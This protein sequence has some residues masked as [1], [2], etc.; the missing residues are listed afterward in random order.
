MITFSVRRVWCAVS[1]PVSLTL[2][3]A[4]ALAV[5][6]TRAAPI[7]SGPGAAAAPQTSAA[8]DSAISLNSVMLDGPFVR[9]ETPEAAGRYL[10]VVGGCGDCH[11]AAHPGNTGGKSPDIELA[12]NPVGYRGPWGTSYAVNLRRL[13]HQ[14][15][16]DRWVIILKTESGLPPMPWG[17]V[18][19][20]NE[21]DL[22]AMYRY[23]RSLGVTGKRMPSAVPPEKEPPTPY[24]DLRPQRPARS[25]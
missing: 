19:Q 21:R 23:I 6:C 17:N 10:T 8:P 24:V 25:K 13:T 4:V 18:Q 9:A 5:G 11:T 2:G 1:R 16:E 12:G 20:M 7:G 3:A 22:R 15:S 14:I